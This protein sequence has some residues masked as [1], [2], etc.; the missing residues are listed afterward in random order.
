M[1][2]LFQALG[3]LPLRCVHGLGA[4]LGW[5]AYWSSPT[6]AR[7]LRENL[8]RSGVAQTAT[9]YRRLLR[10]AIAEA[11][12]G[13]LELCVVWGRP[14]EQMLALVREC[15]GWEH[16]E[17]A[18]ARGR[19]LIMLTPHLGCFDIAALYY[20]ARLPL[21]VLYRPPRLRWLRPIMEAGRGRG[22]MILA[23]TDVSGVRKLMAALKRGEGIGVLPDQVPGGGEGVWAPFFGRPAYTMTLVGRLAERSGADVLMVFA[24]R[25]PKGRGYRLAF[26]P[27]SQSLTGDAEAAATAMNA[28][29][30]AL[31]RR[32]PT[33]YL[34]SYNRYKTPRGARPEASA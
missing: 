3:R 15:D 32:F 31:V 11:G 14:Y 26:M 23:P 25:L 33:Q 10:G 6:Y 22:H 29:V 18:R 17:A 12:K 16:V 5:L 28:E 1:I 24:E 27:L 30:E 7:R 34:W 4:G 19:G 20:A 13:L 21:T 8:A 2:W 9:E